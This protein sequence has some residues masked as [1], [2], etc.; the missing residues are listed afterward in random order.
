MSERKKILWLV[1]WYP[2]KTDAF[3][4]DFIQRHARAAALYNDIHVIFVKDVELQEK[5]NEDWRSE[6]GLTEQIIYF[7]RPTG[8]FAR[9]RKQIIW[10][11][12]YWK[13]VKDYIY[14]N[15]KPY[16]IHVHVPWK[17]GM[18]ALGIKK[19]YGLLYVVT[20]HSGIYNETVED[21]FAKKPALVKN[22]VR[23]IFEEARHFVSVSRFVAEGVNKFVTQ[24]KYTIVPNVVD[25][26]LFCYT[27]EKN[28]VFTFIHVSN[29][30]SL[31]NV[32]GII[33][34][35]QHFKKETGS[36]AQLILIGNRND[37]YVKLAEQKGLLNSSIF[38]KGEI[39][40]AEVAREMQK[41]HCFVLNSNI[42]NSPCV[43]GEAL[44]C[45]LPVITTNVGGISELVDDTNSIMFPP[46]SNELAKVMKQIYQTYQ[47]YNPEQIADKAAFRFGSDEIGRQFADV[48]AKS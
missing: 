43:I 11:K 23:Q 1:S 2:N 42:E 28:E 46:H 15:G 36:D 37:V 10:R 30:V 5:V 35:F 27:K 14:E 8:L 48:Y 17:A 13:A 21:S 45:G 34:A 44:C 18:I 22:M 16:L 6:N 4:G 3:D 25:T 12:L 40:Y 26:S 7:K 29:M 24:K 20:E 31:K 41:G 19:R 47:H 9:I 38:F 39:P 32:S 33:E